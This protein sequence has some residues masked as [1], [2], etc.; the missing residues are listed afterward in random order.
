MIWVVHPGSGYQ[1]RI[2]DPEGQKGTGSR[3]RN[4]NTFV[5]T[6]AENPDPALFLNPFDPVQVF[7]GSRIHQ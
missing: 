6:N 5:S 4:R 7:P 2:P 3:T 1:I